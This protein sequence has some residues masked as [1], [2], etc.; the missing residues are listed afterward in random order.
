MIKFL[1]KAFYIIGIIIFTLLTILLFFAASTLTGGSRVFAVVLGAFC[2][3]IVLGLSRNLRKLNRE[4]AAEEKPKAPAKA[5]KEVK[6]PE[7]TK[8]PE[9]PKKTPQP[10]PVVPEQPKESEPVEETA[11]PHFEIRI[12]MDDNIDP[13]AEMTLQKVDTSK[14]LTT[15]DYIV[16][17]AET[18]GLDKQEDKIIEIAWAKYVGGEK[19]SEF[20]SFVNPG[21]HI[22]S[23]AS[24]VNHITDAD[25]EN[26]PK[27]ADIK[28]QVREALVGATVVGHNVQFDLAF[29]KNLLSGV[30]GTISYIDTVKLAREAFPGQPSYKLE[31][32]CSALELSLTSTH[33][34]LDDVYATN[35]LFV[36][37][38]A[39][40]K[41]R[42]EAEKAERKAFKE[43]LQ[44]ERFEKYG[45]SPL[46]DTAFVFTGDFSVSREAMQEM[47]ISV[48][49]L[50]RQAVSSNTDYLVAGNTEPL[51]EWAR[52]RKLGKA[53]KLQQKS[54]K[55]KIIS[56]ADFFRLISSAKSSI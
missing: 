6:A 52:E 36:K 32:L 39:A 19:M 8:Q 55:I 5:P 29:V 23:A 54:G 49:G 4:P 43:Q 9:T 44:A 14:A 42:K 13:A 3:V 37:S 22:P 48:G 46:F 17:D 56:E 31:R 12:E 38:C 20:C 26:A 47:V 45:S 51:P 30:D 28:E 10:A 34:A 35:E 21:F 33:R 16:L 2:G 41:A 25:V 7:Q 40:I 11:L 53:Q 15:R 50:V 24:N 1:K 18:T 27:Y